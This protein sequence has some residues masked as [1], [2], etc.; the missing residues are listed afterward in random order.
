M[1]KN[2]ARE[3]LPLFDPYDD[4][5]VEKRKSDYAPDYNAVPI[6]QPGDGYN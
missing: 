2:N 5:W 3:T 6:Y 4:K 1:L